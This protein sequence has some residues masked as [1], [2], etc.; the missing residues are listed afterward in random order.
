MKMNFLLITLGLLTACVCSAGGLE[1]FIGK[2]QVDYETTLVAAK[3]SP[4]Y[5][6]EK[7]AET[8]PKVLRKIAD[9]MTLEITAE[10][11]TFTVGERSNSMPYKVKSDKDG[12]VILACDAKGNEVTL[13][14]EPRKKGRMNFKSSMT[15][16]MDY[17]VWQP[18]EEKVPVEP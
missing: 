2:W 15:D 6:P 3:Q 1:T 13:T 14:F 17:Y 18:V 12:Q 10:E 16:D 8:M 9:R 4:K 7:D 11:V 5:D